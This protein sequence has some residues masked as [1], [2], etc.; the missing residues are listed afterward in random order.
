MK[1]DFLE[2]EM[3]IIKFEME[4]VITTSSFGGDKEDSLIDPDIDGEGGDGG[5]LPD[6]P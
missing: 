5:F 2:P 3:D 1:K 4:D 6:Q